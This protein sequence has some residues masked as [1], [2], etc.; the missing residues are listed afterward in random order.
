MTNIFLKE[1]LSIEAVGIYQA[2]WTISNLYIGIILSS[3]GVAFFP[4]ICQVIDDQKE[5]TKT[6]NDQ[7]EFSLLICLPFVLGIFIF[8]PILLTL[9]YSSE[10]AEGEWI[11]RWQMLGVV[12]RLFGFPFGYALMA[13][14]KAIQYTCAQFL[15]SSLNYLFIV[16]LVTYHGFAGLG[17]N[18]FFA[19]LIY[20]TSVGLF[21]FFTIGY[22]LSAY[23][24]K[25]IFV[26]FILL[27]VSAISINYLDGYTLYL[28][29]CIL[30]LLSSFISYRELQRNLGIDII[31]FVKTKLRNRR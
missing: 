10:F 16:L 25:I 20:G 22:K 29:A 6:I 4:K 11:I 3:M 14:G 28:F 9:L 17:I 12:I 15:F 27:V 1:S 23:L 8:A 18:Y 30:L 5:S 21:C 26:Y 24:L 7:I 2:S 19:Y 31:S 13:K